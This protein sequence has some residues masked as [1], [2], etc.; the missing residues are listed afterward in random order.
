MADKRNQQ[1]IE[2]IEANSSEWL[3][4]IPAV[5]GHPDG[6][7][8]VGNTGGAIV[9]VRLANGLPIEVLNYTAPLQYD[10]QLRIGRKKTD[11]GFFQI[12]SWRETFGG[13]PATTKVR[14]HHWQ[15][16]F[17]NADTVWV[18]RKQFMPLTILVNPDPPIGFDDNFTVRIFGN[19]AQTAT[20]I[21]LIDTQDIDLSS[22]VP[23]AGAK[24]VSFEIDDDGVIS[25]HDGTSVGAIGILTEADI[26]VPDVGKYFLGYAM[27]YE[28]QTELTNEQVRVAFPLGVIGVGTGLDIDGAPADTPESADKWGFWDITDEELKSITHQDL[29]SFIIGDLANIIV[30]YNSTTHKLDF[31]SFEPL[32]NGDPSDPQLVFDANGDVIMTPP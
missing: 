2:V 6:S 10:L 29:F 18:D 31:S 8:V 12:I 30:T 13:I 21:Q 22:Y 19:V 27:L 7:I 24:Y 26:P 3:D 14:D 25:V 11:P 32:T 16:E 17:P 5:M 4:D 28:S 9:W 1:L 23:T 15:H 20:G